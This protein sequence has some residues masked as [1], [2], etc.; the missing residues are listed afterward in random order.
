[1]SSSSG[2]SPKR[3]VAKAWPAGERLR[4]ASRRLFSSV[5][6]SPADSAASSWRIPMSWIVRARFSSAS[7]MRSAAATC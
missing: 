2:L 6:S 4:I 5:L 1:M 3:K 7:A